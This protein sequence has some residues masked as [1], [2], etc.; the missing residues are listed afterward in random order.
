MSC[1]NKDMDMAKDLYESCLYNYCSI[2]GSPELEQSICESLEGYEEQCE[3]MGLSITWRK[4]D[5]CPLT[6][7]DN[8]E[9]TTSG[10]GCPGTCVDPDAPL[11]CRLPNTEGCQCKEGFLLSGNECVPK[12]QCGCR[13]PEGEYY[14]LGKQLTSSDCTIVTKCS[15]ENGKPT[16]TVVKQQI[17]HQ[18]AKCRL[19]RGQYRCICKKKFK[20]NGVDVC[21]PPEDPENVDECRKSTKGTEYKG[22]ISLTQTGRT[23]QHWERQYPHKHVFSKLKTKH[24]Y[25]RNPNNSGQPWCYTIDPTK[26]WEYCKIPMCDFIS[27]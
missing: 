27:L 4:R 25:C 15:R 2:E 17:C 5:F 13:G 6:C 16:L 10:S 24:N 21:T 22:R 18:N 12:E 19:R 1:A 9:Y 7:P 8:M 23:C 20:G 14:P 26:R 3:D 11:T